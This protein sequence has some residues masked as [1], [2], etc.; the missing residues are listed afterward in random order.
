MKWMN[1]WV[2]KEER[3]DIL[4]HNMTWRQWDDMNEVHEKTRSKKWMNAC[5]NDKWHEWM[6][7]WLHE[8]MNEWMTEKQADE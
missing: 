8:W 7:E 1:E 5:T 2:E 4:L 3:H 6:N